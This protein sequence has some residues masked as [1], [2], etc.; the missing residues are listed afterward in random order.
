MMETLYTVSK[1]RAGADCGSDHELL[2]A[3]FILKWK[4]VGNA[5]RP[6]RFDL[7]QITYD[8]T[9]EVANIFRGLDLIDRVSEVD[10]A[11]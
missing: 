3:K 5:T 10:R 4:K 7:S 1:K 11:L 9:A 8:Y 6:F 2:T